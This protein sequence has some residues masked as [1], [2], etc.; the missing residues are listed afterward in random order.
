VG[1]VDAG[2]VRLELDARP[3]QQL[4]VVARLFDLVARHE[5]RYATELCCRM[6]GMG[7]T[8]GGSRTA[9]EGAEGRRPR[10]PSSKPAS[11]VCDRAR[12]PLI[13]ATKKAPRIVTFSNAGLGEIPPLGAPA[14]VAVQAMRHAADLTADFGYRFWVTN[15]PVPIDPAGTFA[16]GAQQLFAF[17][18]PMLLQLQATKQGTSDVMACSPMAELVVSHRYVSSSSDRPRGTCGSFSS[19]AS[20]PSPRLDGELKLPAGL[21]AGRHASSPQ[22]HPGPDRAPCLRRAR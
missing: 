16:K 8:P 12:C 9:L 5:Y 15:P 6:D 20:F 17:E 4:Y 10:N 3:P 11:V 19:T 7:I 18:P 21:A 2:L 1:D 13:V 14:G 22:R